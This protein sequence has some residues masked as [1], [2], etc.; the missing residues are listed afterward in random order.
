MLDLKRNSG[1][2]ITKWK[3]IKTFIYISKCLAYNVK[4]LT[5]TTLSVY[6]II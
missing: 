6:L 2:I 5:R 3:I 4:Y 1:K